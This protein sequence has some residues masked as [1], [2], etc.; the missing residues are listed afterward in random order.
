MNFSSIIKQIL[1]Y[2]DKIV[3]I[4]RFSWWFKI[5]C[6]LPTILWFAEFNLS[7]YIPVSARPIVD[8]TTLP[9]LDSRILSGHTLLHWP[10]NILEDDANAKGFVY[11]LDLLS[12]FVYIIHFCFAWIFALGIYLY[13][14]KKTDA[15]GKPLINPW[16]F[17]WCLGLLNFFSVTVQL[18]WPTAPPWYLELYGTKPPSYSMSGDPAGLRNAD[19]I[20]KIKLFL[21][22]YGNSPIVF[23]SFPSLHGAWPIMITLFTPNGKVF[24]VMG[25]IYAGL[26]WWAA[27]Y[28][29]HH[30]LVDLLGGLLIVLFC[31]MGGTVALQFFVY[32]FKEKI[33]YDGKGANKSVVRY[34]DA[35]DLELIVVQN[36]I[37]L[38]DDENLPRSPKLKKTP[39][40][41]DTASMPLLIDEVSLNMNK[42]SDINAFKNEKHL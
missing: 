17:F 22:L 7:K 8:T 24:K 41:D 5:L 42:V 33:Y 18:I 38:S 40:R 31:Y 1:I 6:L 36:N 30:Y 20:L 23:G 11:F 25:S 34:S 13:Y 19:T 9:Y 2:K 10:R 37:N 14:R 15:N 32:Y 16:T 21:S 12:A 27:M 35:P 29:N 3:Q 26:V 4:Q 39:S 28:L